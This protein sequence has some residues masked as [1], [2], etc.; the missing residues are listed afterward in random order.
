MQSE[1]PTHAFMPNALQVY[2]VHHFVHN[3]TADVHN[4]CKYVAVQVPRELQGCTLASADV[5][6]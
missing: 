4:A 5:S 6:N 2:G 1:N 3:L